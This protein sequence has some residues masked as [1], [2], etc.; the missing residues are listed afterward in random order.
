MFSIS[1]LTGGLS[2]TGYTGVKTFC[3]TV[4]AAGKVTGHQVWQSLLFQTWGDAWCRA[5]VSDF[6]EE[7]HW[8]VNCSQVDVWGS[9]CPENQLCKVGERVLSNGLGW[10]WNT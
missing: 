2:L 3:D 10:N 4:Y 8:L 5:H 6:L 7:H 9:T 1:Q